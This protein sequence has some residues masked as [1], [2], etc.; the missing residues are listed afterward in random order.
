MKMNLDL[1]KGSEALAGVKQKTTEFVQKTSETGKLVAINVAE[2]IQKSALDFSEKSKKENHERRLKKYNP[3]F[4]EKYHSEEFNLYQH[5]FAMQH[6]MWIVLIESVI[7]RQSVY[8][9]K[10][11]KNVWQN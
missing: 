9:H 11:T 4:P 10:H 2:N 7:S 8:L 1:K 5:Q 6:I 3:L